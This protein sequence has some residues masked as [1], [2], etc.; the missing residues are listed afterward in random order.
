MR[1]AARLALIT[2]L[3]VVLALVLAACGSSSSSGGSGGGATTSQES[4]NA[5]FCAGLADVRTAAD[6]VTSLDPK[7]TTLTQLSTAMADLGTA[8][9][10][11]AAAAASTK[12]VDHAALTDA[13]NGLK[14]AATALPGSGASPS[15]AVQ[16]LQ[17][18]LAALEKA[19]E[20]LAPECEGASTTGTTTS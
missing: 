7:N 6:A 12:G 10:S 18:H 9:T 11:F 1:T 3:A 16:S 5:A 13:W 19:A 15:E 4:A 20:G 2:S 8:W 17:P 14:D